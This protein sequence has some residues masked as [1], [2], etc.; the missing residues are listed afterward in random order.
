[1]QPRIRRAECSGARRPV[2]S[3]TSF[4]LA[5]PRRRHLTFARQL[6]ARRSYSEAPSSWGRFQTSIGG[7][8]GRAD[9]MGPPVEKKTEKT[10]YFPS[11]INPWSGSRSTTPTPKDQ[12]LPPPPPPNPLSQTNRGDHSI[13]SIYGHSLKSYPADCPP[14]KVQWF[15]AVDVSSD[16]IISRDRWADDACRCPSE[17]PSG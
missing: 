13:S 9:T 2:G 15:H 11:A 12:P 10:S 3:H 7:L 14:L 8:L 17:N 4:T 5:L 1:M 6:I 16:I